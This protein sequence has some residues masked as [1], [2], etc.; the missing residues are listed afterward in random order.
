MC[1]KVYKMYENEE[2]IL[3]YVVYHAWSGIIL[4]RL[5]HVKDKSYKPDYNH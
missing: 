1:L 3:L 4:C 2:S 5:W